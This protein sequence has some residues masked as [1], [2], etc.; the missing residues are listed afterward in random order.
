MARIWFVVEMLWH[1]W[2][3]KKAK[4]KSAIVEGA[5]ASVIKSPQ[6]SSKMTNKKPTI[7]TTVG[8][9]KSGF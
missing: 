2:A 8:N 7:M 6:K 3:S 4:Q 5:A 1:G 9:I